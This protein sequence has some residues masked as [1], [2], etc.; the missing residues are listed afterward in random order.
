MVSKDKN[1]SHTDNIFSFYFQYL[2]DLTLTDSKFQVPK[3]SKSQK[4]T[5]LE[6][7]Q[8]EFSLL[9]VF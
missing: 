6:L 3:V 5:Q 8:N 1:P 9:K 4:E 2:S 7:Q